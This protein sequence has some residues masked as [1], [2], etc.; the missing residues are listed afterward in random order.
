MDLNMAVAAVG[1][2]LLITVAWIIGQADARAR[3]DAWGRIAAARKEIWFERQ[4]LLEL[5]ER[6]G[7]KS[8]TDDRYRG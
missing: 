3:S 7:R 1:I 8:D 5:A 2:A 6:Q 4:R